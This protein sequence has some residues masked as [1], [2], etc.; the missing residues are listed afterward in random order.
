MNKLINKYNVI[1]LIFI[2]L[3]I[4][5]PKIIIDNMDN[6][7]IR[8]FSVFLIIYYT[9]YNICYGLFIC[10]FIILL[11]YYKTTIFFEEYKNRHRHRHRNRNINQRRNQNQIP[12]AV[13]I[14]IKTAIKNEDAKIQKQLKKIKTKPGPKGRPGPRGPKGSKGEKGE[15]GPI[16]FVGPTGPAGS[17]KF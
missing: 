14:A 10:L 2:L 7:Y 9:K 16:G 13:S 17:I 11:N 6:I 3:T 4:A 15:L 5:F 1:L 12:K 8:L